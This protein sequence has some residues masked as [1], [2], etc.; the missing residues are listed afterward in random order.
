[1]LLVIPIFIAMIGS[2]GFASFVNYRIE[3]A[4][5]KRKKKE[6]NPFELGIRLLL[7]DR[8]E[9]LCIKYINAGEIKWS[10]LKWIKQAHACYKTMK[11]NGDLDELF[12]KVEQL[13]VLY[14][15]KK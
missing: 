13:K 7:Q 9:W 14:P 6:N 2:A 15:P 12:E 4:R 5:E 1:M 11:G 10:D 8:I 3:I